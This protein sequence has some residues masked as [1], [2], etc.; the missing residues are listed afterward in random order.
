MNIHTYIRAQSHELLVFIWIERVL[1]AY[2]VGGQGHEPEIVSSLA[3]A[4]GVQ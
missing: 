2:S 1:S 4:A 3:Y